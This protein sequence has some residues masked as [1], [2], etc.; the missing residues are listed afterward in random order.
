MGAFSAGSLQDP[1]VRQLPRERFEVRL[2]MTRCIR[3][4]RHIESAAMSPTATTIT[5]TSSAASSAQ[6]V[7]FYEA[8]ATK[9]KAASVFGEISVS[10]AML[11]CD[12][13]ASADPAFYSLSVDAGKMWVNL[14]TPARYLSQ[15]IEQDLVHTGDKIPELLHEELVELGYPDLLPGGPAL[16]FEHFRDE[17]KLYT[18]RTATPIDVNKLHDAKSVEL[19]TMLLLAYEATFRRLG[20]MEAGED[21]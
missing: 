14:K 8:V 9:A 20:D 7:A 21:E 2:A 15:S 5:M 12:A 16:G 17:Q 13:A 18:F 6:L 19:G 4:A 11:K 10:P 1:R 3:A